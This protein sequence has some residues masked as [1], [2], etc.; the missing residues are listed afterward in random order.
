M[1]PP[2]PST[3]AIKSLFVNLVIGVLLSLTFAQH[4]SAGELEF[5]SEG[6]SVILKLKSG[7]S[8]SDVTALFDKEEI[9]SHKKLST[10]MEI[11]RLVISVPSQSVADSHTRFQAAIHRIEKSGFVEYVERDTAIHLDETSGKRGFKV[12]HNS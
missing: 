4:A 8:F 11:Y 6:T 7:A 5:E 9:I 10:S 3:R 12:R 1:H 2:W